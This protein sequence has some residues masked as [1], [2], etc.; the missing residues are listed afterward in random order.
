MDWKK[1]LRPDDIQQLRA[2]WDKQQRLKGTKDEQ[3]FMPV[4][5]LFNP[6]G[7]GTWLITE[8]NEDG[9]AFGLADLGYPEMGYFDL[10]EIADVKLLGGAVYIE[11][12]TDFEADKTLSA[13]AEEARHTGHIVA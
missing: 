11:Q 2:N 13:Y 1:L 4:A 6:I 10:Q 8:V 5:K 3:D 12:D 7:N 9:L